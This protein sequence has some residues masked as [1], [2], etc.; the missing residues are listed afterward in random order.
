M[1]IQKYGEQMDVNKARTINVARRSGFNFHGMPPS[2]LEFS[3]YQWH[4][5]RGEI[6]WF[7][8]PQ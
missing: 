2:I 1:S 7:G 4:Y 8:M 6:R 3:S 5:K